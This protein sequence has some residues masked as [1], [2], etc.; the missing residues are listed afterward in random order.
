MKLGKQVY[1]LDTVSPAMSMVF[2]SFLISFARH[3]PPTNVFQL[4][5]WICRP[6]FP[7]AYIK[8]SLIKFLTKGEHIK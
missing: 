2:E 6:D 5:K 4:V 8:A 1:K 3:A 7:H